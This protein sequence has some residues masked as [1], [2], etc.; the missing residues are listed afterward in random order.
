MTGKNDHDDGEPK[1]EPPYTPKTA[2]EKAGV[3][4]KTIYEGISKQQFP[5]FRIG[6]KVLIPRRPFD[7]L[8]EEGKVA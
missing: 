5:H 3:H 1:P 2:A 6:R 7:R 8:V 4:R